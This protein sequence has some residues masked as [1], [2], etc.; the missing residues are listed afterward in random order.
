[1]HREPTSTFQFSELADYLES[2]V[3]CK[4][5]LLI[6]GNFDIHVDNAV[7]SDAIKLID[8]SQAARL[9]GRWLLDF[10]N[11]VPSHPGGWG[12]GGTATYGL[13]RYVPLRRVWVSSSLL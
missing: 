8:L 6:S 10:K 9:C 5:Q 13:Y 11:Y 4:E 1:M 3:L 7:G 12:G 2:I